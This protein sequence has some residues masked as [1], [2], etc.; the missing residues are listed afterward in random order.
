MMFLASEPNHN[1]PA[2]KLFMFSL[3]LLQVD[4]CAY[5]CCI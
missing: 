1:L 3:V 4:F 2:G 5:K